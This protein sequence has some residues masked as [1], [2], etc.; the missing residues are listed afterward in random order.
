[1]ARAPPPRARAAHF[2]R[3][4]EKEGSPNFTIKYRD[5]ALWLDAALGTKNAVSSL[6]AGACLIR[7]ASWLQE[8]KKRFVAF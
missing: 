3:L 2:S 1:L 5:A 7:K 8:P 6:K 4:A